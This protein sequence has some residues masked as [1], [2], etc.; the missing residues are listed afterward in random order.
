VWRPDSDTLWRQVQV[1]ALIGCQPWMGEKLIGGDPRCWIVTIRTDLVV[2]VSR[3][4]QRISD[5]PE[6]E[7]PC[8]SVTNSQGPATSRIESPSLKSC[9]ACSEQADLSRTR[10]IEHSFHQ[11]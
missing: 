4:K 2:A 1:A 5:C 3:H 8:F 10:A 11:S 7:S 6:S 9:A